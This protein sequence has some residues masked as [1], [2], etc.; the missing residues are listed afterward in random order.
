MK[1]LLRCQW[2][3][4]FAL[5]AMLLTFAGWIAFGIGLSPLVEYFH[6]RLWIMLGGILAIA[7]GMTL[8]Y[9]FLSSSYRF[10]TLAYRY[11]TKDP[12]FDHMSFL[13]FWGEAG[14]CYKAGRRAAEAE[15]SS[16]L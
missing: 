10:A 2:E 9:A 6:T 12:L 7:I 5:A 8:W 11:L 1:L 13:Q 14:Y 16:R 3:N 4:K 15:W